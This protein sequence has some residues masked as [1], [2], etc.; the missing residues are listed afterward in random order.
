MR[1]T[2]DRKKLEILKSLVASMK[3]VRNGSGYVVRA[4]RNLSSQAQ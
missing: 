1:E 4:S 2:K 3:P